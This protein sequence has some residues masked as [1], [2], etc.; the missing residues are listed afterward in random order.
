MRLK[1]QIHLKF[2]YEQFAL[3]SK[4]KLGDKAMSFKAIYGY[5]I[6]CS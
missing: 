6:G 4:D 5:R 3:A 2:K 1:I